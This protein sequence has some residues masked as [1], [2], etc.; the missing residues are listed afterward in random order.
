MLHPRE[1]VDKYMLEALDK[2]TGY[3]IW[4]VQFGVALPIREIDCS[5]FAGYTL[6]T[7]VKRWFSGGTL[8]GVIK[9]EDPSRM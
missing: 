9:A 5:H 6:V 2:W 4:V 3:D 8:A 1:S 7:A